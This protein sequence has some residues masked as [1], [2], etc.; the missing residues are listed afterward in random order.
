[1]RA[2]QSWRLR[3]GITA[4]AAPPRLDWLPTPLATGFV[5]DIA[6]WRA[7]FYA[8]HEW[9]GCAYYAPADPWCFT[10]L[11]ALL[12]AMRRGLLNAAHDDLFGSLGWVLAVLAAGMPDAG[13]ARSVL[14]RTADGTAAALFPMRFVDRGRK[15]G[16][17][18][19]DHTV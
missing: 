2:G 12:V 10:G 6:G 11:D 16:V 15:A 19:P 13:E 1:M 14:C 18:Q 4:T 9:I 7:S 3:T 5:P 8:M 17:S